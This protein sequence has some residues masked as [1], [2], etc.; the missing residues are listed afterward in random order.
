MLNLSVDFLNEMSPANAFSDTED[1]SGIFYSVDPKL[2]D[3]IE[4]STVTSTPLN[5]VE[6]SQSRSR[7]MSP[8]SR[9]K[10][11][12]ANGVHREGLLLDSGSSSEQQLPGERG[13]VRLADTSLQL[14]RTTPNVERGNPSNIS[15]D[16]DISATSV[17][18]P[19]FDKQNSPKCKES[20]SEL[21]EMIFDPEKLEHQWKCIDQNGAFAVDLN[22]ILSWFSGRF[23]RMYDN[24]VAVCKAFNLV[25]SEIGGDSKQLIPRRVFKR[26][27]TAI[28]YIHRSMN[29]FSVLAPGSIGYWFLYFSLCHSYHLFS[30]DRNPRIN[31]EMFCSVISK[32]GSNMDRKRCLF[33][34]QS[35]RSR[36]KD[37]LHVDDFNL[38]LINSKLMK[39]TLEKYRPSS[40]INRTSKLM[41]GN[42]KNQSAGLQKQ[43]L[44]GFNMVNSLQGFNMVNHL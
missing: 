13:V 6:L 34:Y 2:G 40:S 20:T 39:I 24:G 7:M 9:T 19:S 38:W 37:H 44:Q 12:R 17:D 1:I 21:L 16:V 8:T 41:V 3:K 42:E 31:F 23:P 36:T 5:V 4:R 28:I 33:E 18:Y 43:A 27:L 32:M 25:A 29:C 10:M 14:K 22:Q 35:I 26:L 11:H 15:S 30:V